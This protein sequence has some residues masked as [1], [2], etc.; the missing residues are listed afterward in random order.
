MSMTNE[1]K[2]MCLLSNPTRCV[3]LFPYFLKLLYE[4]DG[5]LFLAKITASL[6]DYGDTIPAGFNAVK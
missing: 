5:Q 3:F 6:N 4:L 2:D 1:G